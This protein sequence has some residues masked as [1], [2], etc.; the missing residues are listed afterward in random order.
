MKKVKLSLDELR[1]ESF[2]TANIR[3]ET[4]T[5]HARQQFTPLLSCGGDTCRF[6][7]WNSCNE[8]CTCPIGS[9]CEDC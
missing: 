5:V 8:S 1:V 7:C 4:G 2:S 6:S 9:V 3:Q